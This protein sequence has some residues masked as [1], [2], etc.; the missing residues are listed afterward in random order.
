M[1]TAAHHFC[2][3]G[4]RTVFFLSSALGIIVSIVIVIA[5]IVAAVLIFAA[6]RPDDFRIQRSATIKAPPDKIFGFINDFHKWST[7]S[8]WEKLDPNLKRTYSGAEKGLGAIY[9][10]EGNKK[11]GQGRM[12]ITQASPP[13][14]L[15]IKLDFIRPFSANNTAEYTLE[16]QGDSTTIT[17]AMLGKQPFMFKVMSLFMSMDKM[18]GKDFEAG[19]ANL[20]GLAEK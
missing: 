2:T 18:V 9:E 8:P 5:V 16:S 10:W 19:L 13:Q 11:V 6:T 14:K 20:K 7:W 4:E 12:E 15:V 1:I 3:V 17:W